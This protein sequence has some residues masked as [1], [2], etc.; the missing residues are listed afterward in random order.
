MQGNDSKQ[1][2]ASSGVD[3]LIRRVRDEGVGQAREESDRIL[4]EA[5]KQASAIVSQANAEAEASRQAARAQIE[6]DR[7]SATEA[8]QMAARDTVLDLTSRVA[9]A[10][11]SHV[12]R[13][14]SSA[15]RDEALVRTIVLVLAGKAKQ[16]ITQDKD[17]E[18]MVSDAFERGAADE[19]LRERS[20]G[21]ILALSQEMLREGVELVAS[22]D[23]TGGAR[24][25]LVGENLEI[26][27]SDRAITEL[28]VRYM[29]P[30]FISILRGQE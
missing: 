3:E 21:L 22:S 7:K 10:F 15:T 2:P 23:V 6:A 8:L 11:E 27:L 29:Q 13:L 1:H 18:I 25:K 4:E 16:E 24:V 9:R 14:V 17:L 5:R 28:L 30:R 26:D 20:K 12:Q 19:K